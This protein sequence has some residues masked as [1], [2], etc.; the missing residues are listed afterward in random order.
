M[1]KII[2]LKFFVVL[3]C[4]CVPVLLILALL[5]VFPK[6]QKELDSQKQLKLFQSLKSLYE[7][8]KLKEA[9][10]KME[11]FIEEV[12]ILDEGCDLV[13]SLYADL[14]VYNF[15][16]QYS[17][18]CIQKGHKSGIAYEGL[19]LSS[20]ALGRQ[21]RALKVLEQELKTKTHDRL[22]VALAQ[23]SFEQ[24]EYHESKKYFLRLIKESSLWSAW[25]QRIF[26]FKDLMDDSSFVEK[27]SLEATKKEAI[28]QKVEEKLLSYAKS[29]KLKV[30]IA[31]LEKHLKKKN[32]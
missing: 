15:L 24:R 14:K 20:I 26:K 12:L 31:A 3:A 23:L 21:E 17:T 30:S 10:S 1:E 22:L 11:P 4:F 32:T 16:E 5:F 13:I 18:R 6:E 8:K 27:L 9:R 19:A 2:K 25:I 7:Q 28:S 29:H